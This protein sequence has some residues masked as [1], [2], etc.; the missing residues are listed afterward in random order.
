MCRLLV[1]LALLIPCRMIA[2]NTIGFP[3]ILNYTKQEYQGGGQNWDATTDARGIMYFANT[4]GLLAFDGHY[5]KVYPIPNNTRLRSIL[6]AADGRIYVG[7]QDEFGYFFPGANGNLEYHSLKSLLPPNMKQ[8]ADVWDIEE[9]NNAIWFR[10]NNMLFELRNNSFKTHNAP[11]EWR[12]M[13][14][15]EK[16]LY[17]QDYNKGLMQL[18][19][20]QWKTI[21]GDSLLKKMLVTSL[22]VHPDGRLMITTLKDGLFLIDNGH[23]LPWKTEADSIFHSGRIFCSIVLSDQ[24]LAIGT[25]SNGCFIISRQNGRIIQQFG[26]EEGLQN[27]NVLQLFADKRKNIWLALDNGIDLIRYNT[28]VKQIYPEKKNMLTSYAAQ[29]FHNKLYIGTSDGVYAATIDGSAD[30]ST[31]RSSF[32]LVPNSKGQVWSFSVSDDQLL[33]GHHEGV[34]LIKEN[35]TV[36]LVRDRGIWLYRQYS[37]SGNTRE[38]L[39]GGYNGVYKMMQTGS[40]FSQP[41]HISGLEES[42]RFIT[43][44]RDNTIWCSHPYRGIYR[45]RLIG[46]SLEYTLLS[47]KDGLPADYEN[48][49]FFIRNRVVVATSHGLYEWNPL[50]NRFQQ[51]ALLYDIFGDVPIQF[52]REDAFGNIWFV[53]DKVPAIVD[54]HKPANNHPYSVVYFPELKHRIV[55]GFEFIYPYDEENVFLAAEKALYHINYKKYVRLS[56]V[57]SVAIG[58]V[59]TIGKND[60]LIFGGYFTG[61]N[62]T[63]TEQAKDQII[64]LP[65]KFNSFRFEFASP[66]YD[67]GSNIQYSYRL[68]G[69]DKEWSNW[70]PKPE[71]EYTNLPY[72][73]YTFVVKCRDNL[74]NESAPVSYSFVIWPAWYQNWIAKTV[75]VI[76]S[77][78]LLYLLYRRQKRKFADQQIKHKKEQDHLISLHQLELERN[79]KELMQVQNE[80]L[81]SDVMFKNR[82][83]ATVTMHLVERGK[84]LSE[85]KEKLVQAITKHDPP[86]NIGN[87]RKVM[88]LL[89]EAENNEDDWEHFARHFDEVHSNYLNSVRKAF[90]SLTT[91]DLKLCAYLHINLTSKE[92]AQLMGISIRGVE[93]SRYRLRK[94]LN[95]PGETSLNS[96]LLEAI[97]G[98]QHSN[99]NG[100][101]HSNGNGNGNGHTNGVN[102]GIN[103]MNGSEHKAS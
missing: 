85:I 46:D 22:H 41:K 1:A 40:E 4:D 19:S 94:K 74:G 29:V 99:G 24:E 17:V 101:G 20:G 37:S 2:Q 34:F 65:N 43:I 68:T 93:T 78:L 26:M 62:G 98:E 15:T 100:N 8:M 92:I 64:C 95:I 18:E 102:N 32:S 7:A 33:L 21:C 86:L 76:L 23:L 47:A 84:V 11:A 57:P 28:F 30:F 53:S 45:I 44:D 25:T 96:F 75:Y 48:Y 71:K 52:L 80:K 35:G 70:S 3:D 13:Y 39:I 50:T 54:F 81:E 12:K 87:F 9:Y 89:E 14:K 79:E 27:N 90:P 67:Q 16:G 6:A 60:S 88:R 59:K 61:K 51:S 42:L 58:R 72:G 77:V 38:L 5:W 36:P 91:T 103:M 97:S 83:L 63:A 31:S 55:S 10:T 73:N 66:A 49:V 69:F 82:E 56:S